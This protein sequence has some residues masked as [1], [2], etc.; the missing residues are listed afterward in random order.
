MGGGGLI[1]AGE[2]RTCAQGVMYNTPDEQLT[3]SMRAIIAA[4]RMNKLQGRFSL[5][6]L[7]QLCAARRAPA[8]CCVPLYIP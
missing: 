1:D 8:G 2:P 4:V 7:R 3:P 6:A 5:G